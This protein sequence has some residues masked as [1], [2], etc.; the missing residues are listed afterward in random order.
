MDAYTTVF[1]SKT[2]FLNK[3]KLK[4]KHGKTYISKSEFVT[5]LPIRFKQMRAQMEGFDTLFIM[6]YYCRKYGLCHETLSLALK[7]KF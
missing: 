5:N 4:K 2:L 3:S 6:K 1:F 7:S